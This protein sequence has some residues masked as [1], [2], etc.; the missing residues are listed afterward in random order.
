ML[1]IGFAFSLCLWGE[2]MG[3]ELFGHAKVKRS[4]GRGLIAKTAPQHLCE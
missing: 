4:S 1:A 3:T 2:I